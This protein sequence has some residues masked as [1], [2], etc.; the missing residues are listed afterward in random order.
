MFNEGQV[1]NYVLLAVI[2]ILWC[3][4]HSILISAG[5][6]NYFKEKLAG[7]YKYYRLSYNLISLLTLF[8]VLF[9][10]YGLN[11]PLVFRWEGGFIPIQ[12]LL[13][14][15]AMI[16][17]YTGARKYDLL[18]FL[19]IRQ[20]QSG[21]LSVGLSE[22]GKIDMTGIHGIIRHPW[23]TGSILFVWV[24]NKNIYL[25][26]FIICMVLT[27]YLIIGAW[28]EE[29]KLIGQCGNHYRDYQKQVSML[30]PLKWFVRFFKKVK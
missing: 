9:Y 24:I 1:M 19:G 22:S 15:I 17:F 16:L 25:S 12:F 20:I 21:K 23:Y 14:M 6:T 30:L 5:L 27:W 3:I 26:T 8:P 2:W 10:S 4:I 11:G 29:K 18:Q 7:R 13:F 28:L